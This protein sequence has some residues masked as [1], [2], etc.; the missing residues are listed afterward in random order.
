[1]LK[2]NLYAIAFISC[3]VFIIVIIWKLCKTIK[4]INIIEEKVIMNLYDVIC[5]A[6]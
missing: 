4:E 3:I 6:C 1:M 2:Y 5:P